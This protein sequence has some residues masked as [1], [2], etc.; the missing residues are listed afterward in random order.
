MRAVDQGRRALLRGALASAGAAMLGGA[1]PRPA[2]AASCAA[3]GQRVVSIGGAVT[4]I[5]YDLGLEDR[6]VAVDTTSTAPARALA[7]KP[8]VGYMRA[9][10]AEA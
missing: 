5:L 2:L 9:L 10:S 4:E 6:I 7:Q 1:L 8:N 3:E